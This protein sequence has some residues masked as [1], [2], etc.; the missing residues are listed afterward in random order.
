MMR[1]LVIF[2]VFASVSIVEGT[3]YYVSPSGSDTAAGTSAS[4]SWLTLARASVH[5][6]MPGDALMLSRNSTWIDD[7]LVVGN[8]KGLTVGAF[9]DESL[10]LPLLQMGRSVAA[11]TTCASFIGANHLLVQNLQISGCSHG[12][13]VEAPPNVNA[14]DVVIEG[15]FFRDIKTPF[16]QYSPGLPQWAPAIQVNG[17]HFSNLTI[18]HN[19]AD[20]VDVFFDSKAFL[21][22]LHLNGNTVQQCG[23]NCYALGRG[24]G[25][26]MENSVLLR[27][28]SDRLFMYGTTDIIVG[29][30]QGYN[31]VLNN[32]FNTRGE[33]QGGPDGCAFDF[34]TS[35]TG[36]LIQGNTFYRSWGA[37]I[38]VFGH[39][40]TSHD[41]KIIENTFAYAGCV[42]NRDDQGGVAVMC[43]SG[44]R[45]SG[46]LTSNTFLTCPGTPAIFV[47]PHV[48]GCADNLTMRNNSIDQADLVEMPQVSFN[49]PSSD[50][51]KQSGVYPVIGVTKTPDATIR[52]TLD[53]SRPTEQSPIVPKKGV[54]LQWP[55]P[56]VAINMRAFKTG[57]TPSVTNGA[58]LELDYVLCRRAVRPPVGSSDGVLDFVQLNKSEAIVKGWI[59]DTALPGRG[60]E[61][62]T[63][64]ARVDYKPVAACLANDPRPDLVKAGVAPNEEHGFTCLLPAAVVAKLK[65]GQHFVD[66]VGVG[67]PSCEQP[68]NLR[69]SPVCFC[70]G[71]ACPCAQASMT[72][73]EDTGSTVV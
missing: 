62:L 52:Y 50:C 13:V 2:T 3:Q 48:P 9:G 7:P 53:G 30:L 35:A 33:Y 18:R 66:V 54:Q 39:D 55:G 11:Q 43:P 28:M 51:S 10:P 24:V 58:I 29:G 8:A 64:T 37:G 60:L 61:P 38:M 34:E 1:W 27:D 44:N 14:S 21:N 15:C 26:L 23:G 36:F 65:T 70:D 19:I 56:A 72:Y 5:A 25:I 20:R 42:Q 47:N 49:P 71:S 57:M 59:V 6:F 22:G 46:Q 16:L 67:S 68:C 12:V 4:T 73:A 41:I 69:G 63:V 31:Q 32:D 45:P 40:S 17:G